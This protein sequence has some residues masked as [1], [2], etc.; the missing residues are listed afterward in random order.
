MD[1]ICSID[2]TDIQ[3]ISKFD[4]RICSLLTV[5]DIFGKYAWVI[6]LKDKKSIAITN[7]FHKFLKESNG[8]QNKT[9]VDKGSERHNRSMKSWL[10]K[11]S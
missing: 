11:N 8:K 2:S 7:A 3:L 5:I 4:K 1:N 6:S 9:W 10:K